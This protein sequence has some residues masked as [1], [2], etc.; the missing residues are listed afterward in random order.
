MRAPDMA[1]RGERVLI[2]P[3]CQQDLND[4]SAWPPFDDPRYRLFDWPRRSPRENH[5]WFAN[6]VHDRTRLYYAVQDEAATVI[7]R[8]SLREIE[9][10]DSARLGIGFGQAYVGRGYGSEA[11]HLFLD[12]YF[13]QMGFKRLVLDVSAF[14]ERAIRCYERLGFQYEGSHFEYMGR[15]VDLAFLDQAPY[16]HLQRFCQSKQRRDWVLAYDMA[17]GREQWLAQAPAARRVKA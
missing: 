9:R 1:L 5:I 12:Y 15:S 17:L 4:M 14:N 11:L 6:L 16:R 13:G 8:I 10:R 3:L 7:G 2:R